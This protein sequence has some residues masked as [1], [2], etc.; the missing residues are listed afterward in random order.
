M[1][2]LCLTIIFIYKK[3]KGKGFDKM[4]QLDLMVLE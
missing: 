2:L 3:Y 4:K 1:L